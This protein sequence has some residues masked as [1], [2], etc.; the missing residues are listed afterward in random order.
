[1]KRTLVSDRELA[2]SNMREY[3]AAI[4]QRLGPLA[5][6][7]VIE[8]VEDTDV[9]CYFWVHTAKRGYQQPTSI[10]VH[11]WHDA[12]YEFQIGRGGESPRDDGTDELLYRS[13][14]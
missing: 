2:V 6:T 5:A 9:N 1:M 3:R 14:P 7:I 13:E 8:E 12:P 11:T 4:I 10:W